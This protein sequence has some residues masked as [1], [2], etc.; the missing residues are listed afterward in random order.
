ME[1]YH[2]CQVTV[3]AGNAELCLILLNQC[4]QMSWLAN[5]LVLRGGVFWFARSVFNVDFDVPW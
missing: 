5:L 1:L 2:N 3:H 4:H